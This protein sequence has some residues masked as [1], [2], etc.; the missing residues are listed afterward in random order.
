MIAYGDPETGRLQAAL[1]RRAG[2]LGLE[3]I[4]HHPETGNAFADLVLPDWS[5]AKA[6][7][8]RAHRAIPGLDAIGWDMA[9]TERGPLL[10]EGNAWWDPPLHR[11]ELMAADDWK[12]F[13]G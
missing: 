10:L 6:L 11:P 4:H 5:D 7:A 12:L 3:E 8:L 1:H 13:L 2:R 9:F